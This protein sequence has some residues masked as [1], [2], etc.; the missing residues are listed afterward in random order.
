MDLATPGTSGT[1]SCERGAL[2]K[3]ATSSFGAETNPNLI[4][5]VGGP[6][7]SLASLCRDS[8]CFGNVDFTS[9]RRKSHYRCKGSIAG[10]LFCLSSAMGRTVAWLAWQ[11]WV[12]G[13]VEE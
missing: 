9:T 4:S 5:G 1:R 2:T 10:F 3:S 11:A 8:Y 12:V 13:S 7:A 6:V